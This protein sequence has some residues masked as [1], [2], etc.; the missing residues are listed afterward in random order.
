[1]EREAFALRISAYATAF[2]G[3]L[4]TSFGVWLDSE[5][6]LL[7][8]L[9]NWISFAMALVS[10]R[11]A[12]LVERPG[13]EE[14]PFGYA[15]FEPAVNT[16]KAFLIL[17]VSIFAL[18]NAIGTLLDGGRPLAAG[19]A[20]VYAV[21]A[22]TG[23]FSTAAYQR[24]VARELASPLLDV[25]AKN[26][27]VNGVISSTVGVAFGLAMLIDGTSLEAAVPYI[28]SSL[29]VLLVVLTVPIPVRMAVSGLAELVA[30][31]PPA[32]DIEAL[33][34]ALAETAHPEIDMFHVRAN[35]VG[36][37]MFVVVDARV[38]PNRRLQELE[39]VR[40]RVLDRARRD[41]PTL[42]LALLFH[43][44]LPQD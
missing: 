6:I 21:V 41:F 9:F 26:W 34:R 16:A 33:M 29:V 36:R 19:W 42:Q 43:P 35:R 5:A 24:R 22:A 32:E 18:V 11:V 12:R 2:F 13:D 31:R 4:G 27:F 15:A 8:G 14:F 25:D 7:D 1:M 37:T 38:D 28:D 23:C 10:L 40:Q 17:G 20:V 39:V 44:E 30:F 3:V